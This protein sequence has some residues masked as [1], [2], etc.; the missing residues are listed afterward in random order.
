MRYLVSSA[1][2][3]LEAIR[4]L[5]AAGFGASAPLEDDTERDGVDVYTLDVT[6]FPPAQADHVERILLD[7]DPGATRADRLG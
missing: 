3:R 2:Q 5:K 6:D 7:V 1:E 4:D